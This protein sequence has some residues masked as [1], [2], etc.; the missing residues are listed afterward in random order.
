[1]FYVK[2][3]RSKELASFFFKSIHSNERDFSKISEFLK[4]P[5]ISCHSEAIC[6]KRHIM[7]S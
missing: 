1:M 4:N 3:T 7:S 5:K 6:R 2:H